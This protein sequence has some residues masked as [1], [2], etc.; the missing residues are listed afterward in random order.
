M[1]KGVPGRVHLAGAS[2]GDG[3]RTGGHRSTCVQL[4]GAAGWGGS[5]KRGA[6][7]ITKRAGAE[8]GGVGVGGGVDR[9]KERR[10][11][12]ARRRTIVDY[13]L[14]TNYELRPPRPSFMHGHI[15]CTRVA[16]FAVRCA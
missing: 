2:A 9:E 4:S 15:L 14:T 7:G 12:D 16:A 5:E 1:A 13:G 6:S 3:R 8:G 11:I 10:C